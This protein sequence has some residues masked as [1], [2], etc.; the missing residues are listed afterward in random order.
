[1]KTH[2][3]RIPRLAHVA[4][5]KHLALTDY[6]IDNGWRAEG[7]EPSRPQN[8]ERWRL[9]THTPASIDYIEHIWLMVDTAKDTDGEFEVYEVALIVGNDTKSRYTFTAS[10][11]HDL[12]PMELERKLGLLMQGWKTIREAL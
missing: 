10:L 7:Q 3:L 1:M 6:L 8:I 9:M 11:L 4:T 2:E 12:T 5:A